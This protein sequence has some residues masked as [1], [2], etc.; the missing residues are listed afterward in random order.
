MKG[1]I[2][3]ASVARLAANHLYEHAGGQREAHDFSLTTIEEMT[4]AFLELTSIQ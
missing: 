1:V 4:E 2:L 3:W